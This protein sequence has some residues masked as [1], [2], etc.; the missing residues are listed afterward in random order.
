LTGHRESA[1]TPTIVARILPAK[2]DA[3]HATRN[4]VCFMKWF[5]R[6]AQCRRWLRPQSNLRQ[7][8][9]GGA[10]ARKPRRGAQSAAQQTPGAGFTARLHACRRLGRRQRLWTN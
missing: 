2:L 1:G 7:V 5:G 9:S 6:T 8:D 10:G 3:G 4:V